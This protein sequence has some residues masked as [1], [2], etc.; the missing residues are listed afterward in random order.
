MLLLTIHEI[1][2]EKECLY[3]TYISNEHRTIEP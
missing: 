1:Y 2:M 3:V